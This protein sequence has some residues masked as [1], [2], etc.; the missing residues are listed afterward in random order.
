MTRSDTTKNTV[1]NGIYS[2]Y[3]SERSHLLCILW[4]VLEIVA[5]GVGKNNTESV[6]SCWWDTR[7]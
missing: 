1:L 5:R 6:G 3:V 4:Y 7:V 2:P